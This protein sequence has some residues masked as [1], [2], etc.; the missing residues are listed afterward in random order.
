VAH[1]PCVH[2]CCA[3]RY[4]Q[5]HTRKRRVGRALVMFSGGAA[6]D[7]AARAEE[8]DASAA[9]QAPPSPLT[10]FA[11]ADAAVLLLSSGDADQLS[12]GSWLLAPE[13]SVSP[14]AACHAVPAA[15]ASAAAAA[16]SASVAAAA[17]AS[18]AAAASAAAAAAAA[19]AAAAAGTNIPLLLSDRGLLPDAAALLPDAAALLPQDQALLPQDQA[20]LPQVLTL[21]VHAAIAAAA[22]AATDGGGDGQQRRR[23]SKRPWPRD[24]DDM[25][26]LGDDDDDDDND[27]DDER[28]SALTMD[29]LRKVFNLSTRDAAHELGLSLNGLKR[30]CRRLCIKRWPFRK[31]ASLHGLQQSLAE[32]STLPSA[33]KEV[34]VQRVREFTQCVMDDP[35]LEVRSSTPWI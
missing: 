20:L 28:A 32:N 33:N 12:F 15:S 23:A 9:P 27:S 25:T 14:A 4:K 10:Q 16:A 22:A 7:G 35:N 29:Q 8:E 5:R 6:A 2:L 17:S 31:L 18:V 24:D 19:V 34:L 11:D 30:A 21:D 1:D 26:R 13:V 3:A